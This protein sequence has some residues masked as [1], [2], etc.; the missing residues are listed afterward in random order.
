MS[1]MARGVVVLFATFT[2]V[3]GV[4]VSGARAAPPT[5]SSKLCSDDVGVIDGGLSG[6]ALKACSNAVVAACK[7]GTCF[8]NVPLTDPTSCGAVLSATPPPQCTTTT[9]STTT[10]TTSSTTTSTTSTTTST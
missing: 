2:L 1:R 9:T 7:A 4:L 10:S 3:A 8:C 5:C 6:K